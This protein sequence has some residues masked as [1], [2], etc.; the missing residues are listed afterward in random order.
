[1]IQTEVLDEETQKLFPPSILFV[2]IQL[3]NILRTLQ[4]SNH[5]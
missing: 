2:Y 3:A 5:F 1:M 4:I